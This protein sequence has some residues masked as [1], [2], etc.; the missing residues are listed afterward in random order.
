MVEFWM[1]FL[2]TNAT[3]SFI[4]WLRRALLA[5]AYFVGAVDRDLGVLDIGRC[6]SQVIRENALEVKRLSGHLN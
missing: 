2:W 6:K 1:S 5:L 4:I 3:I